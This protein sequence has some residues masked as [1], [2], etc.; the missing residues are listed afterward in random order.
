MDLTTTL[1]E[2]VQPEKL[3]FSLMLNQFS[4]KTRYAFGNLLQRT[5]DQIHEY[6]KKSAVKVTQHSDQ[7]SN[8]KLKN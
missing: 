8:A 7:Y 5:V 3:Y 2:T 4:D 6:I 1:C